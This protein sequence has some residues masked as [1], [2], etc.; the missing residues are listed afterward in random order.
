MGIAATIQIREGMDSPDNMLAP[1]IE[2]MRQLANALSAYNYSF[3]DGE[4][5]HERVRKDLVTAWSEMNSALAELLGY[6]IHYH[7]RYCS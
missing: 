6:P 7:P 5:T 2:A 3:M 4:D 1:Q